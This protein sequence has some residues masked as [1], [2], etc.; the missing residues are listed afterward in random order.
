L[1]GQRHFLIG[2]QSAK[3]RPTFATLQRQLAELDD[4]CDASTGMRS[5]TEY[6]PVGQ[7]LLRPLIDYRRIRESCYVYEENGPVSRERHRLSIG[8][9]VHPAAS[10]SKFSLPGLPVPDDY[11]SHARTKSVKGSAM[12]FS[13][14][15]HLLTISESEERA[16]SQIDQLYAVNADMPS[17]PR[18]ERTDREFEC[19]PGSRVEGYQVCG[20]SPSEESGSG[21]RSP[22]SST[23]ILSLSALRTVSNTA[24]PAPAPP[25]EAGGSVIT[26][27]SMRSA[28]KAEALGAK[29]N[30]SHNNRVKL[31]AHIKKGKTPSTQGRKPAAEPA[32]QAPVVSLTSV[33]NP[34]ARFSRPLPTPSSARITT[35]D[36][37]DGAQVCISI[38]DN[39]PSYPE[40]LTD[41]RTVPPPGHSARNPAAPI[42]IADK[43]EGRYGAPCA[44]AVA[45]HMARLR[46]GTSKS[47]ELETHT[48]FDFSAA[49]AASALSPKHESAVLY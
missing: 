47:N 38:E 45:R 22:Q 8:G 25:S 35:P 21:T 41:L 48:S 42:V 46:L 39:G 1:F 20:S 23:L 4:S 19:G 30:A 27:P 15:K 2:Q 28:T 11:G 26:T 24:R 44:E 31:V 5:G 33:P 12:S 34:K 43:E 13:Q 32:H 18:G 7:T 36:A 10:Q 3:D 16:G 29:L 49:A 37:D 17:S 14:S 9:S 6:D 40:Y